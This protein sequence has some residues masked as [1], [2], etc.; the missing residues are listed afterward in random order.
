MK[1][2]PKISVIMPN[3]NYSEF[4]EK[5]I[6]S[7]L[8]QNFTDFELLIIDDASTDNSIERIRNY[9]SDTRVR[10]IQLGENK[11][12]YYARNIGINVALG[13]FIAV[14]DADDISDKNR[15]GIQYNTLKTQEI[16]CVGSC[17]FLIDVHGNTMNKLNVPT[18]PDYLK[19]L[20]L[21]N[22]FILHPSLMF[23]K[24][25]LRKY[26]I[27]LYEE[28]LKIA[29]DY[30]F[31]VKCSYFTTIVNIPD[32]LIYYRMHDSQISKTKVSHQIKTVRHVR[33]S[34]LK[35]IGIIPTTKESYIY[36]LLMEHTFLSEEELNAALKFLRKIIKRNEKVKFY[37]E[38]ILFYFFQRTLNHA[39]HLSKIN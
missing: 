16:G 27:T 8:I 19:V 36:N 20:L 11:G 34:Q 26:N 5:S 29:A 14:M 35:R 12:N 7:I 39:Q 9:L 6:E 15:F 1:R 24:L 30:D 17:G 32:R 4:I 18:D 31:V 21:K 33:E 38:D 25:L 13:E 23:N 28:K 22:N 3:Y 37:N 2:F 10:L